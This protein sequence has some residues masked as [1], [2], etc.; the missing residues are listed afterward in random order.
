[1]SV[2]PPMNGSAP[3]NTMVMS[4]EEWAAYVVTYKRVPRLKSDGDWFYTHI[5][6]LYKPTDGVYAKLKGDMGPNHLGGVTCTLDVYDPNKD[7]DVRM[8]YRHSH[9]HINFQRLFSKLKKDGDG[10]F[11]W[12]SWTVG[13]QIFCP[14]VT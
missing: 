9:V 11:F 14:G 3:V 13:N 2:S 10:D 6:G 12:H 5:E 7:G 8:P 4:S 1:M